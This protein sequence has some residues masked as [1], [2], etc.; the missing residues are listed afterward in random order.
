MAAAVI[1]AKMTHKTMV[2]NQSGKCRE[3]IDPNQYSRPGKPLQGGAP[4]R[5]GATSSRA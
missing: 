3:H 2:T 5:R 4:L 1:N